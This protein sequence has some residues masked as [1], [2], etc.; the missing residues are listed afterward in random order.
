MIRTALTCGV[1]WTVLGLVAFA[2]A[3][4]NDVLN[5]SLTGLKGDPARGRALVLDRQ[6]G[7]CLLCHS[8]PFPELSVQGDLAPDL[9]GVGGRLSSGQL[10][11]RLVDARRFN[12]LTL[13]PAYYQVSG[14]TRVAAPYEGR[15]LLT[16][17]E[18]ED[19]VAFL[20]TLRE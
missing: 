4:E 1:F 14:L 8:G 5:Q 9:G 6:A 17:E 10:R 20:E 11:L 15:P 2:H 18:I 7:L 12:P 16:A 19:V 3:Q 13:M